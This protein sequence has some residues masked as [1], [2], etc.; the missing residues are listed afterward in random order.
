MNLHLVNDIREC[1]IL[2]A[3]RLE[4]RYQVVSDISSSKFTYATKRFRLSTKIEVYVWKFGYRLQEH[5]TT[6]N[7]S[8]C[9]V[10]LQDVRLPKGSLVVWNHT[11]GMA[12]SIMSNTQ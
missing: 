12:Y 10:R 8:L 1:V 2:Q 5:S 11:C 4:V 7:Q 3:C 9:Q 6:G